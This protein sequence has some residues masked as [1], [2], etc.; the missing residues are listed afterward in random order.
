MFKQKEGGGGWSAAIDVA[1]L[2]IPLSPP[3]LT[4]NLATNCGFK[5]ELFPILEGQK[6]DQKMQ[7]T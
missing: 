2:T 3:T 6:F 4:T 5:F 7:K 1:F